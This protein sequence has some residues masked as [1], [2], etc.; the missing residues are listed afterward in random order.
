MY[1]PS[2]KTTAANIDAEFE[3]TS[4]FKT[5]S[6][7][8][9]RLQE[10]LSH[11]EKNGSGRARVTVVARSNNWDGVGY[12]HLDNSHFQ[13]VIMLIENAKSVSGR[14][15]WNSNGDDSFMDD[16]ELAK[17]QPE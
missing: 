11:S 13:V 16:V 14:V 9:R 1:D 7:V 6:L 4:R 17:Q 15:A 5:S 2:C 10:L 3:V 8:E 12:G